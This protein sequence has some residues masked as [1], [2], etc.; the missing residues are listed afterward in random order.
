MKGSL[1][2][3]LVMYFSF[4]MQWNPSKWTLLGPPLCVRYMEVFP[5]QGFQ[6]ISS[7]CGHVFEP[8]STNSR[9]FRPLRCCQ[10]LR[11]ASTMS[12][13]AESTGGGVQSCESGRVVVAALSSKFCTVQLLLGQEKLSALQKMEVSTFQGFWIYTNIITLHMD[14][15][16]E[17]EGHIDCTI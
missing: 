9:I 16:L 2:C 11:K 7:R 10:M 5:I 3:I 6:Y 17:Y 14:S 8:L 4:C 13:S 15:W 12:G 1:W